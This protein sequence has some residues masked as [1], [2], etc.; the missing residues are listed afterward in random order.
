MLVCLRSGPRHYPRGSGSRPPLR[1]QHPLNRPS[2]VVGRSCR[3]G[4]SVTGPT[5]T[6][7]GRGGPNI[8]TSSSPSHRSWPCSYSTSAGRR[9]CSC[10]AT[11]PRT[12][13]S[14]G[15]SGSGSGCTS[16]CTPTW[17]RATQRRTRPHPSECT[18]SKGVSEW[19]GGLVDYSVSPG[20]PTGP[21][22]PTESSRRMDSTGAPGERGRPAVRG[23]DRVRAHR[24]PRPRSP[25]PGPRTP[26]RRCSSRSRWR[27]PRSRRH[28]GAS[29]RTEPR[30]RQGRGATVN[31]FHTLLR[32]GGRS[33]RRPTKVPTE[34]VVGTPGPVHGPSAPPTTTMSFVE[35]SGGRPVGVRLGGRGR[36]GLSEFPSS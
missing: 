36:V 26:G 11:S 28:R 19:E 8:G 29:N 5:R 16:V 23:E 31:L 20:P 25:V 21:G 6:P 18:E 22:T 12:S 9:G 10:T 30:L 33:P 35:T 32:L 4:P 34:T 1:P 14:T 24:V 15:T 3:K 7:S 27:R 2:T 13:D 17:G